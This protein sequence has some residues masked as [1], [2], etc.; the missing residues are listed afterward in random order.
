MGCAYTE[1]NK[2]TKNSN[3]KMS[4]FRVKKI[5]S[6]QSEEVKICYCR[7]VP[8]GEQGLAAAQ[9]LQNDVSSLGNN[10]LQRN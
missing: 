10:C 9:L 2:I 6:L 8:R 5:V 3:S 7:A 1:N 4:F